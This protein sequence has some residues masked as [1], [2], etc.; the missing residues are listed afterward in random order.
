MEVKQWKNI[1]EID[2]GH[3]IIRAVKIATRDICSLGR[4]ESK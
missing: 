4:T 3:G 1:I 2:A